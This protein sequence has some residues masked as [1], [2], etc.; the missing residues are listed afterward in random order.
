MRSSPSNRT[1]LPCLLIGLTWTAQVSA[2]DADTTASPPA[3]QQEAASPCDGREL[4]TVFF[5]CILRD[6]RQVAR[7]RSLSWLV[8]GAALAGGSL[9]LDDEVSS[10]MKDADPD[11]SFA[12]GRALGEAGLHFGAPAALYFAARATGHEDLAAFAVTLL[13]TQAVNAA[14]TRGLKLLP[15]ARPYQVDATLT[16][17]SFPSGHTSAAFASATMIQRRWSWKAGVPAYLVAGY[18]GTSRLQNLHH[19]SDVTFGAALGVA[20][21]LAMSLT[22]PGGT[23][24]PLI[25]PGVTG[26]TVTIAGDQD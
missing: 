5:K 12:A 8:G 17:G 13:R 2:Q 21:G 11:P 16:R 22:M 18:V 23:V 15:R 25:G 9:L 20:S 3:P 24:S 1:I 10:S 19:L 7:G 14:L 4:S 6:V 26:V